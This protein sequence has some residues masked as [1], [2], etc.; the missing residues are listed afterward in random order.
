M[1]IRELAEAAEVGFGLW[2]EPP[3]TDPVLVMPSRFREGETLV[4][5][6][7]GKHLD[8]DSIRAH[9]WD[10]R[11]PDGRYQDWGPDSDEGPDLDQPLSM[12][13][14]LVPRS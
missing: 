1:T 13:A 11:L 2:G 6:C 5:T 10:V 12:W 8:D 4:W 7:A 3:R 9:R 14:I